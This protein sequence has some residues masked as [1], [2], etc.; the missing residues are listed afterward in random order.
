MKNLKPINSKDDLIKAYPDRFKGIGKFPGTYNIYLKEDAIPV[1]HTP[2]KCP[3]AIRPLVDK[4]L[5]K[6]LEQDIIVPVT[7]PTDWVSSLAYSWKADGDL[8]TCLNP[9]HLNKAIR[10]D[11]YRTSTLEEITHELAGS[12]KVTKVDGSSSYYCI[13][14]DY[15]SSLLTTFNT[16]RG[17]FRFVR[18]PFGLACAQDIFQR[19][20]DQILDHCEGA[21]G[22]ADDII[23]H[24]KDDA[25]HDRRLH[26]FMKVTREH[27]LV[28]NKKKCEVKS[29]SVKFF[30]CVYDKHGAHPDPSK[31]S[32]IKEMP[33][34]Q[35]KGELQSFL[36]MVT[37]LSPFIPQLSSHTA[38]LRGLLKTDVE[39]SWNATYQV[40][41]DKLKS[42]VCEDTTLR[43]FNMKKPVTI[44][45]DA[46]G[47][48]LGA[49]L[50]Q[51][52]GPVAFASKALTPTEQ[53]YA[54]NERELLAC[55]F[56][57]ERFRTYVFC[58]HFTIESDHKSLEQISMKNLADAPVRLQRM[59]LRLQDYDFTIKYRPGE[60]MVI[61]D[62]LSRYSPEDTPEIL[63][64][65][66]VNHVYIN[67]EKKRDYQLAIKDDP[68]LSALA[69]TIITRLPDDIKDVP[70]ALRPYHGQRD[71]LTV[72]DGLILCG[73]AIIVPPGERKRSWNKSI[74]DT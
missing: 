5:D 49:A 9:T 4:K 8:R 44:Q 26:K 11:H 21:I 55:V 70:K 45:V 48:G 32:A 42:L 35:N 30:G 40:A 74:K 22:I 58:R 28:L 36:G 47:K 18:L 46:S 57:A 52:D 63:L 23:I 2:R 61:A 53:C 72:E 34:P 51:D 73:E 39:Y 59:L 6:L 19:M 14:L 50:I 20:M 54:N 68:L 15:E 37:Y 1:V 31:V 66:S 41:F 64:D 3:I 60:E 17:R 56:G 29:N 65:I 16:H 13:V 10:Q 62:T 38:T 43:Y 12:T 7:E 71:S 24:G 25:E 69:Y 67:A 33:A 27:G